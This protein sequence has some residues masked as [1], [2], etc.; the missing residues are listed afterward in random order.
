MKDTAFE[1]KD[2]VLAYAKQETLDPLK[3]LGRFVAFGI[4][5]AILLSLGT[6]LGALAVV[7]AIQTETSPHLTGNLSWVPYTGGVLFALVVAGGAVS[8]IGKAQP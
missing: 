7:R 6:I 5:G 8:R 1:L 3:A 2:L 4:A